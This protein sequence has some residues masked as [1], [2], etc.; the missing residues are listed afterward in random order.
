VSRL[1]VPVPAV[2]AAV[3]SLRRYLSTLSNG[4]IILWCYLIWYL[5]MVAFHFDPSPRLWLT[6][7]GISIVIGFGLVLS[8]A[9]PASNE[10]RDRWQTVRLF[11]MPLCVSSFSALIKDRGF[12]LVFSPHFTENLVAL[13]ACAVFAGAALLKRRPVASN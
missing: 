1:A 2:P 4:R 5:I 8:V 11:L 10:P 3:V 9:A 6:S 7:V 13:A 12:V